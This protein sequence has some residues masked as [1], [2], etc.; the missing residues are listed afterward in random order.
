[1]GQIVS[2]IS[3]DYVLL[4]LNAAQQLLNSSSPLLI[5]SLSRADALVK[6]TQLFE[7]WL[8]GE[9]IAQ[10]LLLP[11]RIQL[12][13]GLLAICSDFQQLLERL[14]FAFKIQGNKLIISKVPP[15]LR[16]APLAKIFPALLEH[17]GLADNEMSEAQ[18]NDFCV[19]LVKTL[20]ENL[21]DKKVWTEQKAAE[22]LDLLVTLFSQ[23]LKEL[24]SSLFNEPDLSLLLQGFSD[25]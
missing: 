4:K 16:Q 8:N 11:V 1:M 3:D 12:E 9:V 5:L 7:A 2:L 19:F 24:Q 18:V 21:L 13:A 22:L 6:H 10:P 23:Q 14:G 15:L 17:I 20:N 25:D